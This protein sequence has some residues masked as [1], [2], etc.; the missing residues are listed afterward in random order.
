MPPRM[1]NDED[2][3]GFP[4]LS[5]DVLAVFLQLVARDPPAAF[6]GHHLMTGLAAQE[7]PP[8]M[9][10]REVAAIFA[11]TIDPEF[12]MSLRRGGAAGGE[13]LTMT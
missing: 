13:T 1:L 9:I 8:E 3:P 7:P 11:M 5:W 10:R 2:V 6:A 4:S 12:P